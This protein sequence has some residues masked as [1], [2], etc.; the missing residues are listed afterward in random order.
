MTKMV[1]RAINSKNPLKIFFSRT[2]PM[3]LKIDMK[4][5]AIE[6]YKICINHDSGMTLTFC[7]LRSPMHL[8]GENQK[9]SFN[10]RKLARNEQMDRI[11]MLMK[12]FW[13]LGVV[14]SCPTAIYIYMTKIFKHI[15][16]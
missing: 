13:A 1:A 9:M 3:I 16:L 15:L 5:Q 4:H 7:Q 8:N 12:I 14:C 11:F 10:G 2:R 6:L